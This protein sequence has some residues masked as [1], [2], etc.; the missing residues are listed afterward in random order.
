M[1][2][3][4]F[5]MIALFMLVITGGIYKYIFQ[6]SVSDSTDGRSVI[7]LNSTER[8]F[9]LAEM[10]LFLSSVQQITKGISQND[11]KL[12]AISARK[13]GKAVQAEV[14]VTLAAKLPAKFKQLGFDT[15]T[16]FDQ[17]ALDAEDLGDSNH[18]L[19]QLSTLLQNCVVCHAAYRIDISGK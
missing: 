5:A 1:S 19:S 14:P 18:A 8:N 16:K 10:R 12:V 15:H 17:L 4:C 9:V 3:Q 6:N 7:L 2:K 13:S 11:L